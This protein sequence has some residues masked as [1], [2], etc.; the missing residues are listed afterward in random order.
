MQL[1]TYPYSV[2]V[3]LLVGEDLYVYPTTPEISPHS[4]E[5]GIHDNG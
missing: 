2:I 5:H 4:L 3:I 1:Y